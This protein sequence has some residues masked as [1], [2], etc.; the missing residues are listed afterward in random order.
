MRLLFLV[1]VYNHP[2]TLDAVTQAC[3]AHGHDVLMVDDGSDLQTKAA[4]DVVVKKYENVYLETL[5]A[6]GGKGTAVLAG[7]R[8]AIA[9]DYTHAFQL[10]ADGQQDAR[11]IAAFIDAARQNPEALI[12]GYPIYNHSVPTARKW[13]RKLTHFWVTINTLSFAIK[14]TLCGFRVYP[15]APMD[16]FLKTHPKLGLRMDFDCDIAVQL[17][18]RGQRFLNLPVNVDYPPDGI[19]HFHGIENW[20]ITKMHTRNFFLMLWHLPRIVINRVRQ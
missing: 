14:D 18:W 19:S 12:C 17:S 10:D 3:L 5:P 6:N 20:Y 4:I 8:W 16:A 7:F 2:H 1:P 9:R 15:L 11:D 13:G